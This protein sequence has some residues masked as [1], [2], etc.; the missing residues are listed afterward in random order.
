MRF[1]AEG[2]AAATCWLAVCLLDIVGIVSVAGVSQPLDKPYPLVR[3]C[4]VLH[5]LADKEAGGVCGGGC[6]VLV[7]GELHS[8]QW[9]GRSSC[10][11]AWR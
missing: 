8:G 6:R 1:F 9:I 3:V 11:A 10:H 5:S 4:R 2:R 7:H